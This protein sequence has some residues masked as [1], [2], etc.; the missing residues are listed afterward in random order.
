MSVELVNVSATYPGQK[1]P[2]VRGIDLETVPGE[3]VYMV[4]PSGS[5]KST[6]INV[7]IG[8][9]RA[10]PGS[11]VNVVGYDLTTLPARYIWKLRRQLGIVYQDYKLLENKTVFENAAIT[12]ELTGMS[13]DKIK[14]LVN[15]TLELVGLDQYKDRKPD[16][17]SGG[18]GQRLAIARAVVGRPKLLLADEPTGNLDPANAEGILRLL[19]SIKDF[20]TT[21]I[22]ATHD[23]ALVDNFPHRVVEINKGFLTRDDLSGAYTS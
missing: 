14:T 21:I 7:M 10:D 18:E 23:Q 6:L 12:L 11:T 13:K 20:G 22:M 19:E 9:L 2:A 5:G 16:Q 4:G 8:Q 1:K 17:L 15:E 3:F